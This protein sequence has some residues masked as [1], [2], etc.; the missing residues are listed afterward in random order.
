MP[1][2]IIDSMK[3]E[4]GKKLHTLESQ[5]KNAARTRGG[6]TRN[7]LQ[8]IADPQELISRDGRRVDVGQNIQAALTRIT[9]L[10]SKILKRPTSE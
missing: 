1:K 9:T 6:L 10:V 5:A 3:A 4:G 2:N 8:E 7:D